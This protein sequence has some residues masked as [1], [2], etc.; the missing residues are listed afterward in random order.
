MQIWYG[1]GGFTTNPSSS[2]WCK[3]AWQW[4]KSTQEE[5]PKNENCGVGVFLFA[6]VFG[7]S[8]LPLGRCSIDNLHNTHHFF[9]SIVRKVNI[10]TRRHPKRESFTRKSGHNELFRAL[11]GQRG[12]TRDSSLSSARLH[13]SGRPSLRGWY[14]TVAQTSSKTRRPVHPC[15]ARTSGAPS[16]ALF[17]SPIPGPGHATRH[18]PSPVHSKVTI[19]SPDPLRWRMAV[20]RARLT[21]SGG[22]RLPPNR[23]QITT[24]GPI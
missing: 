13:R 7:F 12:E 16:R 6:V 18:H 22:S 1:V 20:Y 17:H 9:T 15:I 3:Y 23:L 5:I 8:E 2:C 21:W 14:G 19:F 10:V 11:P 24:L 4:I